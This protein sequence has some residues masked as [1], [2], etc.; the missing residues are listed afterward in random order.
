M[1]HTTADVTAEL[2]YIAPLLIIL[3]GGHECDSEEYFN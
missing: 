1:I 3:N 2:E